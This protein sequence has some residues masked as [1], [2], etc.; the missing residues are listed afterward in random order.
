MTIT[1]FIAVSYII[2]TLLDLLYTIR[3]F[4]FFV[5]FSKWLV[6]FQSI[7]LF[8]GIRSYR[9][10]P[11]TFLLGGSWW[12][13]NISFSLRRV[14]YNGFFIGIV[15]WLCCQCLSWRF[16]LAFTHN[17]IDEFVIFWLILKFFSFFYFHHILFLWFC[18]QF[19]RFK[20]SWTDLM[21]FFCFSKIS[22]DL[23]AFFFRVFC[24]LAFVDEIISKLG[25]FFIFFLGDGLLLRWGLYFRISTAHFFLL[26]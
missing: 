24:R 25:I 5:Q 9:F 3:T 10:A 17:I 22:L 12:R 18:L 16:M 13:K 21:M 8:K 14:F 15:C 26:K 6:S 11:L 4:L 2:Q 19:W 23:N 20:V 1:Y 7:S